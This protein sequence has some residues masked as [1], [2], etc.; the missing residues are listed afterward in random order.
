MEKDFT[1]GA[2]CTIK[3]FLVMI[4]MLIFITIIEAISWADVFTS[5]SYVLVSVFAIFIVVI[6]IWSKVDRMI[7]RKDAGPQYERNAVR[8]NIC[9][10]IY[11]TGADVSTFGDLE[12]INILLEDG[13]KIIWSYDKSCEYLFIH[14]LLKDKKFKTVE[15]VFKKMSES[16]QETIGDVFSGYSARKLADEDIETYIEGLTLASFR[17]EL[18]K[19]ISNDDLEFVLGKIKEFAKDVKV[20]FAHREFGVRYC[21]RQYELTYY[22]LT[23]ESVSLIKPER[24]V[25][26]DKSEAPS[27]YL[28]PEIRNLYDAIRKLNHDED[29]FIENFKDI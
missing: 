16:L 27:E 14:L 25:P 26:L 13:Y 23:L 5:S 24:I 7:E 8:M 29:G 20:K 28:H 11:D 10:N 21:N 22:G 2:G 3:G 1:S 6:F 17:I 4:V 9:N 15:S 18:S 12:Y 19:D